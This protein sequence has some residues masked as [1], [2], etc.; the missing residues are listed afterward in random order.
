M[1]GPPGTGKTLFAK[2]CFRTYSVFVEVY[3]FIQ[4]KLSSFFS[5]QL[6]NLERIEFENCVKS[7]QKLATSSG[8]D[9]AI[10]TGGD[11]APMGKEGVTAIHKVFDWGATS[12]KG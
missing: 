2:V 11:I 9:Y 5:S 1:Y 3:V 10:I 8:M 6:D 12:R 7:L 4:L